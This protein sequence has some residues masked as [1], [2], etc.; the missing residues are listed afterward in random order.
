MPRF[1]ILEHDFPTLHWDLF[2]EAGE[3][4]RTWRLLKRPLPHLLIP[5]ESIA[6]HRLLYLDYEG[7]VSGGRGIVHR[8][9]GGTFDWLE[10]TPKSLRV[11]LQSQQFHGWLRLWETESG[12]LCHFEPLEPH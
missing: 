12:W 6:P 5:A 9:D 4:L 1:A 11:R 2:L 3:H 10:D 7:P 8:L